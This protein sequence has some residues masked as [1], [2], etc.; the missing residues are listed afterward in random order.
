[1]TVGELKKV[2]DKYIEAHSCKDEVVLI[3]VTEDGE[4]VPL[5]IK[6]SNVKPRAINK[7]REKYVVTCGW[8]YDCY[9]PGKPCYEMCRNCEKGG[10]KYREKLAFSDDDEYGKSVLAIG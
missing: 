3:L 1:M 10:E 5:P 2:V 8:E 9:T 7:T 6:K 4:S